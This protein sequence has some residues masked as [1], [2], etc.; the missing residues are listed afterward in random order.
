MDKEELDRLVAASKP[1]RERNK[2]R[3]TQFRKNVRM[4]A[5]NK[6]EICRYAVPDILEAH[7]IKPLGKGGD[8]DITNMILLCPNCHALS[9][10]CSRVIRDFDEESL[11]YALAEA[12][13]SDEQAKS[14]A[15]VGTER[16]IVTF[17]G[18]IKMRV[19]QEYVD[20]QSPHA[21]TIQAFQDLLD[22]FPRASKTVGE[23][24]E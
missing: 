6:C 19:E 17:A 1:R 3:S 20:P 8:T 11:M 21:T 18:E 16:A 22:A 13:V 12:G 24:R 4:R 9:H 14:L 5:D 15:L 10:L 7:H 23:K 2:S